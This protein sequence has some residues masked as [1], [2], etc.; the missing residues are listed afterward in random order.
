MNHQQ[1]EMGELDQRQRQEQLDIEQ[2]AL[3]DWELS[4]ARAKL[5]LKEKHYKV[6]TCAKFVVLTSAINK[7]LKT[8]FG[9]L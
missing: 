9:D 2:N 7:F 3:T 4:Y 5:D 8:T 6:G 1:L